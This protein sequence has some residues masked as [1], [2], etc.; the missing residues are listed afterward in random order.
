MLAKARYLVLQ[1][2]ENRTTL[3]KYSVKLIEN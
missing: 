3:N 1:N 2:A